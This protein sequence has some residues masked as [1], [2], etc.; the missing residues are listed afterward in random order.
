MKFFIAYRLLQS[1]KKTG[2]ISVISKISIL[3]IILGVAILI[4]VLSVMNGFEKELRSKI[5]GFTSHITIYDKKDNFNNF[6]NVIQELSQSEYIEGAAPYIQREALINSK[7]NSASVLFRAIDPES[8]K[9]VSTVADNIIIGKYEDFNK[10]QD[11]IIL[12]IGVA[13]KLLISIGDKVKLHSQIHSNNSNRVFNLNKTYKVM[14]IYDIGLYEY[15]NAFVFINLNSISKDLLIGKD[16][17]IDAFRVKLL[18]PLSAPTIN[19]AL[20]KKYNNILVQDWTQTHVSLFTAIHNEKRVMFIILT[21]IIAVAAF[22]IISSLLMLV[23]N[24]E[25]DIAILM[26]L[27]AY[28]S[29][30]ISIFIIQGLLLG[31]TGIIFGVIL[32][33]LL[34]H[35]IDIIIRSIEGFFQINLLPAEIYHLSQVPSIIQYSDILW[36]SGIAF[37]LS[38]IST[39]YPALKASNILPCKVFR[40]SN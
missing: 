1:Q 29:T 16:L 38:L 23:V 15:N 9:S 12:G 11:G 5:L 35:N 32:G 39:I 17:K 37:L 21:L 40:T 6:N 2:F 10:Y 14:G 13:N 3:G 7:N 8:E 19:L 18:N 34:S 26:T 4:T 36:I 31:I 30:V 25:K 20:S 24:K 22:N 28:K 33:L 27:G